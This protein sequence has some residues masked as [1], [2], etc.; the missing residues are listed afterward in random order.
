[1]GAGDIVSFPPANYIKILIKGAD[2][3]SFRSILIPK[4]YKNSDLDQLMN[5]RVFLKAL[6]KKPR[7]ED[8][9]LLHYC[10]LF[11]SISRDLVLRKRLYLYR[12]C[13]WFLQGL[14]ESV[15]MEIFY[16]Y[17]IDLE[18]DDGLTLG[19]YWKRHI[20]RRKCLADFIRDN[21]TDRVSQYTKPQE[22]VPTAP[23]IVEPFTYPEHDLTWPTRF[24]TVQGAIQEEIPVVQIHASRVAKVRADEVSS[25][26]DDCV[27]VSNPTNDFYENLGALFADCKPVN[28]I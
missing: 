16:T 14:P 2:W 26:D 19:I 28:R 7:S 21:E 20:K 5:S 23:N 17:E 24:Q 6:K 22:K 8:D 27:L 18:D 10:Q 3:A 12:Q 9:D 25:G 11:A 4:E 13:Q 1:M 15:V